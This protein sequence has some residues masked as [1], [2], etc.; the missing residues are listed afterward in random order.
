MSDVVIEVRD[1]WKQYTIGAAEKAGTFRELLQQAATAPFRRFRRGSQPAEKFWAL[2]GVNFD[3]KQGEVLGVIGRNGAGKST[4]LKVLSRIT[5]PTRGHLKVRGRLG[6][7]LEVGTGFH[8]ELTGRENIYLNGAIL[9]MSRSDIQRK[10]DDIVAFAEIE[11]FLDTPVKHYSSGMTLRLGFAVAAQLEPD[12]LVIDEILAVGDAAFQKKCLG[13]MEQVSRQGRTVIFVSHQLTMVENLCTRTVLLSDGQVEFDGPTKEGL[14]RYV[15]GASVTPDGGATIDL[16]SRPRAQGYRR[17]LRTLEI[18]DGAGNPLHSG[19][20]VGD[21]LRLR[22]TIELEEP[23]EQV[24]VGIGFDSVMG[25]RI[26]GVS[27]MYRPPFEHAE[28]DSLQTLECMI[29][30]INL[31]PGEYRIT[32]ALAVRGRSIDLLTDATRLTVLTRDYYGTGRMPT[33][34]YYIVDHEWKFSTASNSLPTH[35]AL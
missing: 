17:A 30:K 20:Q 12:V 6:S 33:T 11:R 35:S 21:P 25:T 32:C 9:G 29:P 34:G 23:T 16:W 18:L 3:V 28:R 2:Q 15:D 1:L 19:V 24:D 7:L 8:P 13:K 27:T 22:L 14:R 4:L 26:C 10:L 5:D 31:L